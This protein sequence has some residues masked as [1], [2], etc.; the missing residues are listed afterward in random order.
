M[1]AVAA[2]V[3]STRFLITSAI[4]LAL[5]ALVAFFV[6]QTLRGIA[7]TQFL[8]HAYCYLYNKSLIAL[9]LGSDAAIWLSYVSISVTLAYLVYRTRREVPFSWMLLAFGT[10]IIACGFTHFMEMVVLWKPLYWLSVDVKLVTAVASVVTAVALPP[11]ISK[12][13]EMVLAAQ[14][15]SEH[16]AQLEVANQELFHANEALQEQVNKRT[17]AEQELR[18]L[19][20]RLLRLQDEERRRLARELHDSTGQLLAA[21]QLNLTVASQE[22]ASA[23]GNLKRWLNET[24]QLANQAIGEVRTISYLLHPPMLD[25]AG[26]THALKWYVEGFVQRSQLEVNLELPPQ[27]DRLPTEIELAIFRIVQESLTNIHRHSGSRTADISLTASPNEV[28]LSIRDYGKGIPGLVADFNNGFGKKIGVGLRGMRERVRQLGGNL[29][30]TAAKPGTFIEA[31][32][33]MSAESLSLE[34]RAATFTST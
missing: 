5:A 8:P 34:A 18:T 25:E 26:L 2:R 27:L 1:E 32:V 16:K 14:T 10:F 12:I 15:A 7:S 20:G 6:P 29:S 3:R 13:R 11:L 33:P 23:N 22:A 30:I 21:I 19:S 24:T 28:R 17:H 4:T 31:C 9:N